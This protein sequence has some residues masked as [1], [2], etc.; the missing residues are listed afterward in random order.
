V[1]RLLR[2]VI[3]PLKAIG[4]VGVAV[5]YRGLLSMPQVGTD[6]KQAVACRSAIEAFEFLEQVSRHGPRSAPDLKDLCFFERMQDLGAGP[7]QAARVERGDLGRGYEVALFAEFPRACAVIT[8]PR[9]VQRDLH[10]PRESNGATRVCDRAA[11]SFQHATTLL[12]GVSRRRREISFFL[13]WHSLN[14][15]S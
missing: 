10:E 4:L 3:Q 11:E 2:K 1:Y 6:F 5:G 14:D 8:Q 15:Y 9:L 7:R 13:S 12:H